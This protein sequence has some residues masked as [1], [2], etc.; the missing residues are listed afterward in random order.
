MAMENPK[1]RLESRMIDCCTFFANFM[2]AGG[3]RE[4][5]RHLVDPKRK[6]KPNPAVCCV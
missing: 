1:C 5:S 2:T 4:I 6:M 3:K